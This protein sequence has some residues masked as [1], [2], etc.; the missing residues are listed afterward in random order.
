MGQKVNPIGF[1]VGITEDWSSKWYAPKAAYGAFLIED[2]KIR[3]LIDAKR[4][5]LAVL[6]RNGRNG[7]SNR[8]RQDR[9]PVVA[10][11]S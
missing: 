5:L 8:Q 10:A 9:G 7:A 1:R 4:A 3:K 6:E 11:S 2:Y